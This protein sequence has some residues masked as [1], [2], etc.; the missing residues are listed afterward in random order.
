MFSSSLRMF[1]RIYRNSCAY[2]L[3]KC[4][5]LSGN[6]TNYGATFVPQLKKTPNLSDSTAVK[7]IIDSYDT[8]LVDLDGTLWATDHYNSLPGIPR[9]IDFLR[10][11]GKQILFVT[12]NSFHSNSHYL[13]KF[14][15]QGF[16]A[17]EHEVFGVAYVAALYL[18]DILNVTGDI[19]M[20]GTHGMADEL[21]KL[22]LKHFGL[23]R[24]PDA[25]SLQVD[26]LLKMEFRE[27]VQAVLMGFDKDFHYNKIYKAASYL[28][29][30]DC[31][32]IATNDAE[33]A[34]QIAPNR[35]QPTTGS[36][37]LSVAAASK[38]TPL[39]VGKP[40]TLMF[41]C[42]LEKYPET[43]VKRTV[44]VG[45]SLKADIRFAN[46]VGIDS[47]LVLTGANKMEDFKDFPDAIPTYVLSSFADFYVH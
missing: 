28:M 4:R 21:D 14:K 43:D 9:A 6:I 20:L 13:N 17:E 38:R 45:D 47:V 42:I 11:K 7:E 24:D 22:G 34:V 44:F 1:K 18:K 3:R 46:N 15:T 10:N 37:I 19:Y 41:D 31:H 2:K 5:N 32:F 35:V 40:H 36:L 16:E 30:K 33:I 12:N 8:F 39:V 23:G 26:N 27:N 25:S 29:D